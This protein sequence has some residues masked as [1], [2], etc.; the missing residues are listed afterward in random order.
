MSETVWIRYLKPGDGMPT[1]FDVG[2][3]YSIDFN[4]VFKMWTMLKCNDKRQ[5]SMAGKQT[6][7]INSTGSANRNY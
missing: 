2:T 5:T 1:G 3:L 6:I 7:T 4:I